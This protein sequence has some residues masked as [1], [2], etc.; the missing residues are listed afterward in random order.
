MIL[1]RSVPP[2]RTI[3]QIAESLKA[4]GYEV[5]QSQWGLWLVDGAEVT[6]AQMAFIESGEA[7]SDG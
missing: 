7:K 6:A 4:R 1:S 3:E 2:S 5:E